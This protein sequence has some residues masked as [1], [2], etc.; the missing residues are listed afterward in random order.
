MSEFKKDIFDILSDEIGRSFAFGNYLSALSLTLIIPDICASI[1]SG[2][3]STAEAQF[4][5]WLN[6]YTCYNDDGNMLSS[7]TVYKIRCRLLHNGRFQNGQ[8]DNI[9]FS[10]YFSMPT[11]VRST[12]DNGSIPINVGGKQYLQVNLDEFAKNILD[13]V[14]IWKQG[15]YESENYK[16]YIKEAVK[17]GVTDLGGGFESNVPSLQ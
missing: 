14:A 1:D 15:A 16:N 7:H 10:I 8:I 6:K 4:K 9:D 2:T 12:S 11:N 3:E 13:G 17:F 5:R